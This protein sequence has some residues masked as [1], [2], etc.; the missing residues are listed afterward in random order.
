ME[1]LNSIGMDQEVIKEAKNLNRYLSKTQKEKIVNHYKNN[2]LDGLIASQC[3]YGI[4]TGNCNSPEAYELIKKCVE[5]VLDFSGM[6]Y[7][8]GEWMT[9]LEKYLFWIFDTHSD[10]FNS[11]KDGEEYTEEMKAYLDP[12]INLITK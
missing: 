9:P 11:E 10:D 7:R 12:L 5:D 2:T 6:V 8:S 4:A 1:N 3:V